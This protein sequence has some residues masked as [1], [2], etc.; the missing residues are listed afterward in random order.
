MS[1]TVPLGI[2]ESELVIVAKFRERQ[3][4]RW[5]GRRARALCRYDAVAYLPME[6]VDKIPPSIATDVNYTWCT[7]YKSRHRRNTDP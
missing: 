5:M 2:D 1:V 6:G 4:V 3:K 7:P